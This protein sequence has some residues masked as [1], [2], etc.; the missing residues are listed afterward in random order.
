MGILILDNMIAGG[1]TFGTPTQAWSPDLVGKSIDILARLHASTWGKSFADVTWLQIGSPAVQGYTE[2]LMSEAHWKE[3]LARPGAYQLIPYTRDR[4]RAMR[5]LRALWR[6][7]ETHS[8]CL[9]HGDAHLG[10]MCVDPSGQPFF[11]DWAGPSICNWAMDVAYF[12]AGALSVED[13]RAT[14]KDLFDRYLKQLAI[15]G[16]P[17]PERKEAWD[18]FGRHLV[19]GQNWCVLPPSMHPSENVYAMGERHSAAMA[20]H[21]TY[22]LLGV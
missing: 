1:Y 11:I 10:N 12:V 19:N 18:D 5:A 4:E 2:V 13:R 9:V 3:Q 17:T 15:N 20:D 6:Y 14:E 8:H 21:D 7:D 16:G 22:T